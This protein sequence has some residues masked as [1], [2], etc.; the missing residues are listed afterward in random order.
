MVHIHGLVVLL[1]EGEDA[2]T[3]RR[4]HAIC[5]L[6]VERRVACEVKYFV[7]SCDH[8]LEDESLEEQHRH[9][10]ARVH[11]IVI[12]DSFRRLALFEMQIDEFFS[13]HLP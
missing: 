2:L 4:G 10:G 5:Y 11:V 7:I 3:H 13:C 6:D 12:S 1:D 9:L 8:T